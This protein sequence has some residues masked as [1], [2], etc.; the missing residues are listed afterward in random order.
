MKDSTGS[1]VSQLWSRT[2]AALR[3]Q[4]LKVAKEAT[5]PDQAGNAQQD[6]RYLT[7]RE[8]ILDALKVLR[9][10]RN[11]LKLSVSDEETLTCKV[12][13]VVDDGFLI[14]DIK[15]RTALATLRKRPKFSLSGRGDGTYVFI[16]TAQIIDEGQ[17]SELP[18]F[19]VALPSQLLCQQR[20]RAPRFRLPLRVSAKGARITLFRDT[21]MHGRLIDISAGGCRAAFEPPHLGD[22]LRLEEQ[23]ASC[24]IF[25]PPSL[26]IASEAV[27]RHFHTR[28][29]GVLVCG[30]E[31][32]RMHVADRRR[33]EIFIQSLSRTTPAT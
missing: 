30:L 29:D 33:L 9:D 10:Q 11:Q 12:L 4:K 20:R 13:D 19:H 26:E 7:R 6:S 14:D 2:G 17:A 3:S 23:I 22:P 24:T 21:A 31:L 5:T 15:P 28:K 25:L 16:E 8:D 32:T 1:P 27:L 18:Y